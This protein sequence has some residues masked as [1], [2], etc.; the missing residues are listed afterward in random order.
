M[1]KKSKFNSFYA[2][3]VLVLFALVYY[4]VSNKYSINADQSD[5]FYIANP[6]KMGENQFTTI[7]PV[8]LSVRFIGINGSLLTIEEAKRRQIIE[9]V[10]DGSGKELSSDDLL[11]AN[12]SF[13]IKVQDISASPALYLE[14]IK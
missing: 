11:V 8:D 1:K 9:Q 10:T 4:L 14:G 6:L 13:I 3:L 2:I 12:S 7:K 5:A